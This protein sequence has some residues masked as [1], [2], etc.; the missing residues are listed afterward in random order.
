MRMKAMLARTAF[1]GGTCGDSK[2]REAVSPT[3]KA[4]GL[5]IFNP[6]VENWN[7]EAREK[8]R[9]IKGHPLTLNLFV[10]DSKYQ[11]GLYTP[12][13]MTMAVHTYPWRTLCVIMDQG[14]S[15]KAICEDLNNCWMSWREIA[16]AIEGED[17]NYTL[18]N[19]LLHQ[20]LIKREQ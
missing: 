6:V 15:G 8:E 10:I 4:L 19:Q 11:R 12:V 16:F 14:E 20:R 7:E 5:E 17:D 3:I 2:W 13:E 18:L 9:V 1:L